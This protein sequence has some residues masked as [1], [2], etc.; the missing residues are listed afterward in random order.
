LENPHKTIHGEVCETLLLDLLCYERYRGNLSP[1]MEY[2]FDRHVQECPRCRQ[3][4]LD[5]RTMIG[6]EPVVRNYG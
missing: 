6:E 3:K 4:I 5:F 2:L 1:E